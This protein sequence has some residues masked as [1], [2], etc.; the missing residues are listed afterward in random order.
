MYTLPL[1]G[2]WGAGQETL[3]RAGPG[4]GAWIPAGSYQHLPKPA[5]GVL[6]V[7]FVG[8]LDVAVTS[9]QDARVHTKS[10]GCTAVWLCKIL[11]NLVAVE[12]TLHLQTQ[13]AS[14]GCTANS[15]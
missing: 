9:A 4:L 13:L 15:S 6:R 2:G 11:D 8:C 10:L 12:D 5:G 14:P 7:G 3:F 1:P